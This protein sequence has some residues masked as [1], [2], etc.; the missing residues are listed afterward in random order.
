MPAGGCLQHRV[1]CS[2]SAQCVKLLEG[3]MLQVVCTKHQ[4]L[5]WSWHEVEGRGD[6]LLA[7]MPFVVARD[8]RRCATLS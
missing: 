3:P 1:G 4:V 6:M 2:P 5:V 7:M 8:L